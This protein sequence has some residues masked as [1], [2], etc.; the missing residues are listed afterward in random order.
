MEDRVVFPGYVPDEDLPVVYS[1]ADCFV[2]PSLYEGFGLPP[3]EAMACGTPVVCSN[4]SS[5]P[6]IV[7]DAA[8]TTDPADVAALAAGI[9][10]V[11]ADG[12]LRADLSARGLRRAAMFT[13]ER[14]ARQTLEVYDG[15]LGAGSPG[16]R[17]GDRCTS[18]A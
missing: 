12:E 10:R 2:F 4:A 1:A 5:L 7:G 13:W 16:R 14:T 15:L 17:G 6:E 8:I 18:S 11:L 9:S 3:L